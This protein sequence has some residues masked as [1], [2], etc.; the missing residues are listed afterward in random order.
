MVSIIEVDPL[1]K[2]EGHINTPVTM[3]MVAEA[4]GV[5]QTTVSLALRGH[6]RIPAATAERIRQVAET[7]GYR[8]NP[9][10]SA[11]AASRRRRGAAVQATLGYVTLDR[12]G[13]QPYFDLAA[14]ARDRAAQLGYGVDFL[15]LGDPKMTRARFDQITATRN[16]H[17]LI[18][19]PVDRKRQTLN[20][21]WERYATVAYGYSITEPKIHRVTPDFYHSMLE[22][23]RRC[24][25]AGWRRVGLILTVD[26]DRKSDHFWLA[27]FLAQQR[28]SRFLRAL[29]PLLL[30]AWDAGRVETWFRRHRPEVVV[31]LCS[32]LQQTNRWT[33]S[34]AGAAF[35]PQWVALNAD[36]QIDTDYA[37]VI[38]NREASGASCVDIL[39]GILHRNERG[40][41]SRALDILTETG[42]REGQ[43]FRSRE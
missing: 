18:V 29:P 5:H 38:V 34:Q 39:V 21:S 3:R 28:S 1:P 41:P 32:I 35:E 6:P 15:W 13:D 20:L 33:R 42:W 4:A 27:A 2:P 7:L 22:V 40:I 8:P 12:P 16:I 37:G 23:L 36:S 26:S 10:V 25:E 31:G 11:L 24:E 30:P 14:G 9:L 17:G 43:S 19:A